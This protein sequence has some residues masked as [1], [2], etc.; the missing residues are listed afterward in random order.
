MTSSIV[1]LTL[2]PQPLVSV[3]TPFFNTAQYLAECIESVLVQNYSNFEYIL[4]DNCS[5]DG[6]GEIAEAYARRD[7]RIR[8]IRCAEFLPQLPNYN[9]AL[10]QISTA[11]QYC[12]IVQADDVI[13]PDCLGLMVQVLERS[14]SIGLVSSYWLWG[15]ELSGSGLPREICTIP[16]R[17]CARWFFRTGNSIFGTQTQVMYRSA[18]VRNQETFYNVCFGFADLQKCIEILE[19]WDFGFVHQVLSFSR[20]DEASIL[21]KI[22]RFLPMDMMRYVIAQRYA[23]VFF[24]AEE[25]ASVVARFKREYYR[26][27]ARA[28]LHVPDRAF[29]RFHRDGRTAI[30]KHLMFDWRYFISALGAE[31]LWLASNPGS[32]AARA[33]R[34]VKKGR[35]P[36][37]AILQS[38][39]GAPSLTSLQDQNDESP[40]RG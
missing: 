5:N 19:H 27:L 37:S 38:T 36:S 30:D 2:R 34:F 9:R 40:V 14:E 11:S 23:P 26:C 24:E 39:D 25:A 20:V 15:N 3:V 12:K 10:S 1:P 21:G 32:T 29:W 4:L 18:L 13:S 7:E 8:V 6:S 31:L 28:A 22:Q 35:N 17:E 33:L 16:G